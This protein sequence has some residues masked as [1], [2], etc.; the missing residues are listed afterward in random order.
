MGI[1]YNILIFGIIFSTLA[2]VNADSSVLDFGAV[3][4]GVKDDTQAFV[5]A[6]DATCKATTDTATLVVPAGK[7]FF[8][9]PTTFSGPC[10]PKAVN[11]K[12]LGTIIAPDKP[13]AWKDLDPSKWITFKGVTG[14]T[15]SG[16]GT[17]DGRGKAWWDQSCRDH[18]NLSS[19]NFLSVTDCHLREIHIRN[20]PQ[21]HI[22]LMGAHGFDVDHVDI[23]SPETSPNTDGIHITDSQHVTVTNSNFRSGDDCISI[24]DHCSDIKANTIHCGPGHGISIGSLGGGGNQVQVEDVHVEN[25]NFVGTTNGVRIK[26]YQIGTGYARGFSFKT[27]NFTNVQNPIM[28]DQYYCSKAGACKAEKTG[29]HISNITYDGLTGTSASASAINLNCSQAVACTDLKFNSIQL[30]SS[31]PGV[32]VG[33]VCI[34]AH[35]TT[36]G[37]I[38]PG[39]SCL[40]K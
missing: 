36:T 7:T 21:T 19:I 10:K 34:N 35:G 4:D 33:S 13:A 16:T 22:L 31:K 39:I 17:L 5:K 11:F 20:S 18:P 26:T 27:I 1:F 24:G 6:W 14:L 3:G 37:A 25:V 2:H 32:Q 28:I 38:Q 40:Q 15:V 29:V 9:S 8:L 30:T 23:N 12:I